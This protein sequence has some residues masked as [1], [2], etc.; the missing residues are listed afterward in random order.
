MTEKFIR[1]SS[2]LLIVA[3]CSIPYL[4]L[5]SVL[6]ATFLTIPTFLVALLLAEHF[7]KLV[8]SK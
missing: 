5:D 8:R 3:I 6:W 1:L 7:Y 4:L 2:Y